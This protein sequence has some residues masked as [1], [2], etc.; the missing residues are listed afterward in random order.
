VGQEGLAHRLVRPLP[1]GDRADPGPDDLVGEGE[2]PDVVKA[3]G[4]QERTP[5]ERLAQASVEVVRPVAHPPVM[6]LEVREAVLQ[7]AYQRFPPGGLGFL[8]V[9]VDAGQVAGVADQ[10]FVQGHRRFSDYQRI[11]RGLVGKNQRTVK[12]P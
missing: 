3:R 10:L 4:A 1:L 7:K 12:T 11:Q 6:A 8:P 2:E 5:G 9:G